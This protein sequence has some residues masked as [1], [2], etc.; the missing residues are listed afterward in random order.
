MKEET[1]AAKFFAEWGIPIIFIIMGILTIIFRKTLGRVQYEILK[2]YGETF[3]DEKEES[4]G[5]FKTLTPGWIKDTN[6][7]GHQ[8]LMLLAGI[9]LIIMGIFAY[10]FF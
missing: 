6:R 8:R 2:I 7:I 4:W 10:F 5:L 9:S 3:K 1:A